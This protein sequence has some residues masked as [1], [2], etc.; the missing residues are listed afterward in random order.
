MN[1]FNQGLYDLMFTL[2]ASAIPLLWLSMFA[3]VG[4]WIWKKIIRTA[5]K[6]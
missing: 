2:A 5:R 3:W 6:P 1:D 4:V